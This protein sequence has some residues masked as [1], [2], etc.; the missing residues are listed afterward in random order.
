[1][2]NTPATPQNTPSKGSA[3][4]TR[5][6]FHGMFPCRLS[7]SFAESFEVD[8]MLFDAILDLYL[9]GV[10]V[11]PVLGKRADGLLLRRVPQCGKVQRFGTLTIRQ[12]DFAE[13]E[14]L[15][16]VRKFMPNQFQGSQKYSYQR[17]FMLPRNE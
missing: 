3:S 17:R 9:G 4:A 15:V 10:H 12:L 13:I 5:E 2:K 1:M 16:N 14:I 6:D 7:K 11:L 8:V